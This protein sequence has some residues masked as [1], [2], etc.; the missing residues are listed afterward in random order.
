MNDYQFYAF[1]KEMK[2]Q[3][4]ILEATNADKRRA[5]KSGFTAAWLEATGGTGPNLRSMDDALNEYLSQE[6]EERHDT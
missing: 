3:T 2:K 5:Y 4:K 6:Q 1:M